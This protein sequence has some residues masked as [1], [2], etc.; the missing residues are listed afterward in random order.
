[1][2]D[3]EKGV[4]CFGLIDMIRRLGKKK[5]KKGR[6]GKSF[7]FFFAKYSGV[8]LTPILL[9]VHVTEW[10]KSALIGLSGGSGLPFVCFSQTPGFRLPP[11]AGH[12]H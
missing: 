4:V 6:G 8:A 9:D 1:M 11:E 10:T 2:S 7:F 3:T 12:R 5:K